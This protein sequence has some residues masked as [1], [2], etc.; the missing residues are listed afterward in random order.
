LAKFY[1]GQKFAKF[2]S[3]ETRL[4]FLKRYREAVQ[5]ILV[6]SPIQ[7]CRDSNDDKFLE[8]A[9]HGQADLILTGDADLLALDP[10]RGIRIVKPQSFLASFLNEPEN[11]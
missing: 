10:F 2:L 3:L 8:V 1:T 11:R 9:V 5:L 7:A 4:E 6:S